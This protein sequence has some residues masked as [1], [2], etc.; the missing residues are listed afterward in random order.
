MTDTLRIVGIDEY[1]SEMGKKNNAKYTYR[2]RLGDVLVVYKNTTGSDD[3]GNISFE[4][5]MHEL[6]RDNYYVDLV[7]NNVRLLVYFFM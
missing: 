3:I 6:T 4:G 5:M 1:L 7:K 2:V